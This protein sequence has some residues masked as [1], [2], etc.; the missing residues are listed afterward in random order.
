MTTA[1][2]P[3]SIDI[4]VV[5]SDR[6]VDAVRIAS[7]RPTHVSGLFVRHVV[8]EVPTLCR[9]VFALCGTSHAIAAER[10]IAA[11]FERPL[12]PARLTAHAVGLCAERIAET[13]RATILGS[14]ETPAPA[15]V[16]DLRAV[17]SASRAL[18]PSGDAAAWPAPAATLAEA[19]DR[20]GLP[21]ASGDSDPRSPLG[22]LLQAAEAETAF[23][24]RPP[25]ALAVS[26]DFAVIEAVRRG[27]EAF[28]AAPSL[29][30]RIVETGAYARLW[31]KIPGADALAARLRARVI[32]LAQCRD[33]LLQIVAG[34]SADS[35]VVRSATYGHHEG[36]A[37]LESPRGR[38]Y[39][40]LRAAADGRV[41]A[42]A[43]VAP[44]EWNFHPKG[45]F[46]L[47]LAGADVGIGEAA[48]R[49]IARL[50]AAFDPCVASDVRIVEAAHA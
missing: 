48:R 17:L 9:K 16:R 8:E 38:L 7:T 23:A 47:A 32:D 24:R 35:D 29:P 36:F 31:Q 15:A 41:A 30:G 21:E 12:D 4:E 28:A 14:G 43:I 19:L 10:A 46:V 49:R 33:R 5:L 1:F 2:T 37:A 25:D 18:D 44:T 6:R 11:A 26:D 13:L 34:A 45:P 27:G 39:H 42:Y 22:L 20:L 50:A 40:W 3:G